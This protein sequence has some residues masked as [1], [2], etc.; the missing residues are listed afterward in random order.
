MGPR[1]GRN[2]DVLNESGICLATETDVVIVH[3][4]L[5]MEVT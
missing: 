1:H 3:F 4:N 5:L 2:K